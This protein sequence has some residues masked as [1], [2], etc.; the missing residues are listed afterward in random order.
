[1]QRTLLTPRLHSETRMRQQTILVSVSLLVVG[2]IATQIGASMAKGLFPLVGATG[3]TALRL[4][5]AAIIL[6]VLFRPW[7]YRLDRAQW[8]AVL[9]YGG[10][11]GTMNLLFY[12]AL[13]TIPLGIAVA[14]EFIGPLAVALAG[15]RKPVDFL[16]VGLAVLG[17]LVLLP[18]GQISGDLDPVGIMLAFGAGACWAAYIVFGQRAST[19]GGAHTAALGVSLAALIILPLGIASAGAALIQ[20]AILPMALGV[21]LLSSAIPYA[22]DML[23]LPHLPARTYG[24]LMSAEPALAAMSGFVILAEHLSLLQTAGIVAIVLASIGAT[25]T[26]SRNTAPPAD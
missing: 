16:W 9:L 2:M 10:S 23:V 24:I 1:M 4:T 12:S 17:L 26:I 15:S 6:S 25:M 7:R 3:A 13:A 20:P 14:I 11:M 21:A 22:I 18:V 19:G 5:L 8:R